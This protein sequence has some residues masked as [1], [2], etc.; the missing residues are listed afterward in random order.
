MAAPLRVLQVLNGMDR[1]GAETMIMN[2][3]R[4][5]DRSEIQFDFILFDKKQDAFNEEIMK[6]GGKIYYIPKLSIGC[7]F[8]Y[9]QGWKQFFLTHPEY[10][11]RHGHVRSTASIYLAIA[12]KAGLITIAHSHNTAENKN[13]LVVYTMKRILE[14]PI[15]YIADYYFGCSVAAGEWL[16]GKKA[17]RSS[18]W[19]LLKNAVDARNFQYDPKSAGELKEKWNL[20]S[21]L[22]VGHVGRFS[23]Q[24]NHVGL[25]EIFEKVVYLKPDSV[26]ILIGDGPLKKEIEKLVFEKGLEKKV[27]FA[28]VQENIQPFLQMIDV[29]VMPSLYEGL[30]VSIIEAQAAGIPCVLSDAI[31]REVVLSDDTRCLSLKSD[32]REWAEKVI[33][34]GKIPKKNNYSLIESNGYDIKTTAK[35]LTE[36]YINIS[37][38][39]RG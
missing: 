35:W 32:P 3:Y 38:H 39:K 34:G 15:R 8:C 11:I 17:V 24:K 7:M 13:N 23:E 33:E 9:C 27:I 22:V 1:A 12:E 6:L 18:S 29:L 28:G 31:T 10:K 36:F 20:Q 26:L 21:K 4:N 5:I 30:P 19:H 16:F 14:Y 2:L 37:N 25:I